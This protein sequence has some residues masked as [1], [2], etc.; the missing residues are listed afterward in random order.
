MAPK[1]LILVTVC[2]AAFGA[3]ATADE[4]GVHRLERETLLGD[5]G[6]MKTSMRDSGIDVTARFTQFYQGLTSGDGD[7]DFEYGGK[8]D[9]FLNLDCGKL[10]LWDG[11]SLTIHGEANFGDNANFA[12]GT[13][14]PVNTAL[15]FPGIDGSDARDLT[16]V[17]FGKRIGDRTHLMTGKI[18]MVDL[19]AGKPFMGGAGI[20]SFQNI[21]FTAPP[22]GLVPPVIFGALMGAQTGSASLTLAVY[23]PESA[24]NRSGLEDPFDEGVSFL[25]GVDFP[26]EI[27]GRSG[28]YGVKAAASTRN[29]IDLRDIPGLLL[30]PEAQ[31]QLREKGNPYFLAFAFDQYLFQSES[32]PRDGW[33]L[34]GQIGISDGNPTPISWSALVGIGG[35][36]PLRGRNRDEFGIGLYHYALSSGLKDSLE[37]LIRIDDEQGLEIF[38][39][40]EVTPWFLVSADFQVIDPFLRDRDTAIYCGLRAKLVL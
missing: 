8:L 28:T 25:V 33:G 29:G 36:S 35:S 26:A 14:L 40:R 9:L 34:F 30:P 37:P 3:N 5:W 24:L 20:D 7:H 13:L 23:D 12:G 17:F 21:A 31:D 39:K 15:T 27:D 32:N 4:D 38:Y 18:N 1:V 6:G 11:V 19:A 2:L 22:S 16:S 10:G